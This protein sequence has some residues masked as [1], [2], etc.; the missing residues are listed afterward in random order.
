MRY[1]HASLKDFTLETDGKLIRNTANNFAYQC[2]LFR[3][4]KF[5][6]E[7]Q[8]AKSVLDSSKF[9]IKEENDA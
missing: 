5:V 3:N 2:K 7:F 4:G 6:G 9:Y 8:A 1:R